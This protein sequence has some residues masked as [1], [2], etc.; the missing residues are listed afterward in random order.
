MKA[1]ILIAAIAGLAG[2]ASTELVETG[3]R[4]GPEYI[5]NGHIGNTHAY[6]YGNR[7]LVEYDGTDNLTFRLADGTPIGAEFVSGKYYRLDRM[8]THFFADSWR[9]T[10][11]IQ[12]DPVTRVFSVTGV[13]YVENNDITSQPV[14]LQR[15]Q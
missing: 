12:L 7:T 14:M 4:V 9:R 6:I 10:L 8:A 2:C 1:L 15:L 11:Q 3:Q 13:R 5:G